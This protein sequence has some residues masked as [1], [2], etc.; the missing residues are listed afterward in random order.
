MCLG[1]VPYQEVL[2][3]NKEG[4]MREHYVHD[5][6]D[7]PFI[8]SWKRDRRTSVHQIEA[9]PDSIFGHAVSRARPGPYQAKEGQNPPY[10]ELCIYSAH[11]QYCPPESMPAHVRTTA[12]ADG[13]RTPEVFEWEN[14]PLA[15]GLLY[16]PEVGIDRHIGR[17]II[18]T[19][20]DFRLHQR[21]HPHA[22]FADFR[23]AQAA[24][25]TAR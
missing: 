1:V 14:H 15:I 3:W 16:H 17:E 4:R 24:A 11:A 13:G 7:N 10:D 20:K 12:H 21:K 5:R 25:Q 9:V 22:S 23:Q 2:P 8:A 6:E 18:R 19:M